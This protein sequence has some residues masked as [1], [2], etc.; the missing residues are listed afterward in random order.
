MFPWLAFGHLIPSLELAK[1][2]AQKGHHISF[3]STPRNIECLPK[4]SPN[5][6]SFI[7]FVKLAL[8]KVDN[9]LEN[10]EATIDVPYD[11]V[12]YLKKAYDDLEEP[13]TCFLKSSKVDW[14]FYDLILFWAVT[15]KVQRA[16]QMVWNSKPRLGTIVED[17]GLNSR[18]LE[19][20][21]MG[22][23]IPKDER[24]GSFTSDAVANLIRLK[25]AVKPG[26]FTPKAYTQKSSL[27]PL[28]PDSGPT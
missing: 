27:G 6:A 7:K 17:H 28:P 24:D 12:Q 1:L 16:N 9:L 20:K 2:I 10:V 15:I 3:V 8:P 22:Y 18:V 11:V 14:H 25:G 26:I 23:S 19:V 5:L 4:L 13:L 21:K